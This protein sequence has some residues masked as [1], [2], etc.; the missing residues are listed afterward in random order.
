MV[1]RNEVIHQER[2]LRKRGDAPQ[3]RKPI[4]VEDPMALNYGGHLPAGPRCDAGAV[5]RKMN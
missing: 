2:V 4:V 3:P 1:C 5:E